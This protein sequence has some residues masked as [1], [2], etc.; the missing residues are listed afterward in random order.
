ME[1]IEY[2]TYIMHILKYSKNVSILCKEE[3]YVFYI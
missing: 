3:Y 2:H 1:M